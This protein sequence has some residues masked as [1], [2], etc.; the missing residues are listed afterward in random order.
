MTNP[1]QS[2]SQTAKWIALL[3]SADAEE[4]AAGAKRLYGA[5]RELFLSVASPWLKDSDFGSLLCSPHL[6]AAEAAHSAAPAIVAGVAVRPE[7]FER[8]RAANA[9]PRLA[10]VPPDQD[11][12]EFELHFGP[13]ANGAD[14][15][16]LTTREPDGSGAIARFLQRFG[17]GI[18]QIEI[19]V[20]DV[21]RA[22]QILRG[23]FAVTPIY[24]QTRAGA[25]GTRVNFFLPSAAE[26]TKVLIELVEAPGARR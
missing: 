10:S 22:T 5:A 6:E 12:I 26:G 13:R 24:P 19:C 3:S 9:S 17:E 20:R 7:N 11:A 18:Q 23:K 4:R 25:D 21:D 1:D 2:S 14:L 8:I 16:I 15:D